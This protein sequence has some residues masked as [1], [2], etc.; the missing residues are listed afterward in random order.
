VCPGP[1]GRRQFL[2]AGLAGL[3][4]L[5]LEDLRQVRA[6]AAA[7]G[8]RPC[9]TAC[10][11]VWQDGGP[12]QLETYDLKPEAP[13]EYRG[14]FRPTP[15]KVPGMD[16]CELLPRHTQVADKFSL[17]RSCCHDSSFHGTGTQ[18]ML[19][20]RPS[21][22]CRAGHGLRF[23]WDRPGARVPGP[24]WSA[25]G[26]P[27]GRSADPGP[28]RLMLV[29][30][31]VVRWLSEPP[32][33]RGN[34]ILWPIPLQQTSSKTAVS[35]EIAIIGRHNLPQNRFRLFMPAPASSMASASFR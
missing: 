9:D 23:P 15:S 32:S 17:I 6:Q 35:H 16:V 33:K 20:G 8:S 30:Y 5:W 29:V 26:D 19:T 12:S 24:Q 34:G 28:C 11:L 18:Q 25:A 14:L 27:A 10:I 13:A 21:A 2:R 4:G 22:G 1:M 31:S 3:G 7:P